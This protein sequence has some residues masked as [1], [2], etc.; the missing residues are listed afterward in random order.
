MGAESGLMRQRNAGVRPDRRD[1]HRR[2]CDRHR[3]PLRSRRARRPRIDLPVRSVALVVRPAHAGHSWLPQR[4]LRAREPGSRGARDLAAV[5]ARR[6]RW[7]S[8][9]ALSAWCFT[10]SRGP[11]SGCSAVPWCWRDCRASG[12]S[13]PRP[14]NA[15]V[16]PQPID[17]PFW[18]RS[19]SGMMTPGHDEPGR[20]QHLVDRAPCAQA[21]GATS[22]VDD[23]GDRDAER[24]GQE[25]PDRKVPVS[26]G[27]DQAEA[28]VGAAKQQQ[29]DQPARQRVA[30]RAVPRPACDTA[31]PKASQPA[32][33]TPSVA[34]QSIGATL[35]ASRYSHWRAPMPTSS[36]AAAA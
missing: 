11:A 36:A 32:A 19:S 6:P 7:P 15:L 18:N 21:R 17:R 23:R 10:A 5:S 3:R 25:Q 22:R 14:S 33:A 16:R 28:H 12:S 24:G 27:E 2:L 8:R 30:G 26:P 20:E 4:R 13:T 34:T 29:Q 35:P 9:S 31:R 1:G